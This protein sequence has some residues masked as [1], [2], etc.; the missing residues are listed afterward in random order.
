M[1]ALFLSTLLLAGCATTETTARSEE[2]RQRDWL[3]SQGRSAPP[4]Q[5]A[6]LA[7]RQARAD[8][9][10]A[11]PPANLTAAD[12]QWLQVYY[13]AREQ[14]NREAQT[15]EVRQTRQSAEGWIIGSLVV[16]AVVG[17]VSFIFLSTQDTT[18]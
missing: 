2:Q 14:D 7:A 12:L 13:Q 15:A 4:E 1:R 10:L 8:S 6:A 16:S 18:R 17:V 9:L 11:L 3:I 5:G